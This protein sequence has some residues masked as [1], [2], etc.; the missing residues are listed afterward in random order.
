[1]KGLLLSKAVVHAVV[2]FKQEGI[3]EVVLAVKVVELTSR[4]KTSL[5][6]G[7]DRELGYNGRHCMVMHSMRIFVQDVAT[8]TRET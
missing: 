8:F 1:M 6:L 3:R 5:V 2:H 7:A 4:S